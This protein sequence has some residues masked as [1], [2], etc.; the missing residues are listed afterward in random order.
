M[1][2]KCIKVLAKGL[3]HL[4]F[5]FEMDD[6]LVDKKGPLLS[7]RIIVPIGMPSPCF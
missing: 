4:L 3:M 1:F 2:L 5:R 6:A 7:V